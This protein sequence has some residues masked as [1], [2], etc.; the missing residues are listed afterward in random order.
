MHA[1]N[2]DPAL[3]ALASAANGRRL[4]A[5]A[6]SRRTSHVEEWGWWLVRRDATTARAA[7]S[8]GAQRRS[9]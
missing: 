8:R 2:A 3:E 7:R 6:E 4:L 1:D 9:G 5:V